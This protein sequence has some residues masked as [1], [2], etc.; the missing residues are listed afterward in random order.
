L[1]VGD[2]LLAERRPLRMLT[3]VD[4]FSRER[5][6]IDVDAVWARRTR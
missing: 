6:D 5:L 3:I 1:G 4:G 2:E